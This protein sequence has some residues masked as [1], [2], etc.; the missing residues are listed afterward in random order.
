MQRQRRKSLAEASELCRPEFREF[1]D[2]P[3]GG[4]YVQAEPATDCGVDAR[5]MW[6]D[7]RGLEM[8]RS[9]NWYEVATRGGTGRRTAYVLPG[10]SI[11]CRHRDLATNNRASDREIFNSL[12][13]VFAV[14]RLTVA[15]P[16][17]WA[18]TGCWGW[19]EG[20][21]SRCICWRL[22]TSRLHI[23]RPPTCKKAAIVATLSTK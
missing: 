6:G 5:R 17:S 18:M 22:P 3:R 14:Q 9:E 8:L 23:R 2:K 1:V 7:H 20:Y 16:M 19:L 21:R 10:V 11:K 15:M 13:V 12:S 4:G